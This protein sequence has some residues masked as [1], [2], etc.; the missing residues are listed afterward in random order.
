MA[1]SHD[2]YTF[3]DVLYRVCDALCEGETRA[4]ARDNGVT[5]FTR[6]KGDALLVEGPFVVVSLGVPSVLISMSGITDQDGRP[7][8][9]DKDAIA[10][11]SGRLIN[12]DYE[13][14][15]DKVLPRA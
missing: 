8:E 14:V 15:Q 2:E 6:T 10:G 7:L 4:F 3:L 5:R 9:V 12:L 11:L 13:M 1:R